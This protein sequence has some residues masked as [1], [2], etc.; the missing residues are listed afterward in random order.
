MPDLHDDFRA[1]ALRQLRPEFLLLLLELVEL[2]LHEIVMRERGVHFLEEGRAES[3]LADLEHRL[4]QLGARLEGAEFTV[5]NVFGHARRLGEREAKPSGY[6]VWEV[7]FTTRSAEH[8]SAW[9][10]GR[11][12]MP[13]DARRSIPA[14]TAPT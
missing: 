3:V 11:Q 2:H 5:G 9:V 7:V 8:R 6:F 12:L 10:N 4:E 13:S 14:G 1:H